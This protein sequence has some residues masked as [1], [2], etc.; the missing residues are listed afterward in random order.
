MSCKAGSSQLLQMDKKDRNYDLGERE[1]Q[2][3]MYLQIIQFR[4]CN[5]AASQNEQLRFTAVSR[6]Q[7]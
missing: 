6:F 5:D 7:R 1:S 2:V 4:I 3:Q